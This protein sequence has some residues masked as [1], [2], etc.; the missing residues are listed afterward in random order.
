[1]G[2]FYENDVIHYD[3]E[4]DWILLSTCNFRCHYCFWGKACLSK[5]IQP[6]ASP[7]RISAFFD[8]SGLVWLLHIT[9]GEPFLYPRFIHLVSLLIRQHFVSLNTNLSISQRVR[10]F[11]EQIS[12]HRVLFINIALHIEER[13]RRGLISPFVRDVH[14]LTKKGFRIFVSQVMHPTLFQRFPQDFDFFANEGIIIIPKA[15]QGVYLGRK[16]PESYTNDE[17]EEFVKYSLKAENFYAPLFNEWP[18]I[19]TINPLLDRRLI[20]EGMPDHRGKLCY[21]GQKFVRIREDGKIWKCGAQ[22]ILGNIRRGVLTLK[23]GPSRCVEQ[24]CPYF[25]YKYLKRD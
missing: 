24:Q 14:Y 25:C 15:F 1:M 6:I 7:E 9:G 10:R 17:R 3:I 16:Y 8:N 23:D 12:P 19:P 21:A 2:R 13:E 22:E 18:E 20:I 4:A 5:K 11:A